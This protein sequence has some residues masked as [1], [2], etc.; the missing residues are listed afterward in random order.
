M[1]NYLMAQ[2]EEEEAARQRRGLESE[3]IRSRAL[4]VVVLVLV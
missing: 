1:V 3:A 2:T 4:V